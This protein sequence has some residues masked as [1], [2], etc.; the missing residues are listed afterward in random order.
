MAVPSSTKR[1]LAVIALVV[2]CRLFA[3][4]V[5]QTPDWRPARPWHGFNLTGLFDWQ[6]KPRSEFE[7]FPRSSGLFPEEHFRWMREWG[8]NFARLPMDYRN[9]SLTNDWFSI[10][11]KHVREIDRAVA[12][13]RKYGIHVQLCFHRAPGFTIL[14]WDPE[15]VR[16]AESDEAL[17]AFAFQWAYFARRYRGVP[18]ETLSFNLVNEPTGFTEAR[19]EQIVRTVVA[20]IRKEDPARFVMAD[21][22]RVASQPMPSL[23]GIPALGQA[24]RGY[25]PH[26]VSHFASWWMPNGMPPQWPVMPDAPAPGHLDGTAHPQHCPIVIENAPAGDWTL[27]FVTVRDGTRL[28]VRADGQTVLDYTFAV[29]PAATNLWLSN[30]P[31]GKTDRTNGHPR[32][33]LRFVLMA[34][35]R[36][37]E[38]AVAN[39]NGYAKFLSADVLRN[40]R[41][42]TLGA[43]TN[44][45]EIRNNYRQRFVGFGATRPFRST[46]DN[47]SF[48]GRHSTSGQDTLA[49]YS[50]APWEDADKTGEFVMC[51]EFGAYARV[52]HATALAWIEDNLRLFRSR[53][54]GWALW[55]L[56]GEFGVLDTGRTD[57]PL[58]DFN[59]H[60][61]DRK[62]LDLLRRYAAEPSGGE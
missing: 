11:E 26:A 62:L 57:V 12:F 34:P 36:E 28:R 42:A 41:R 9:W 15:P 32:F 47:A 17:A 39:A 44:G 22:N 51:G 35:A 21:G 46:E 13:G 54:W 19:Y 23:Y 29:D 56:D 48:E 25:A 10:R 20:A 37:L 18:N 61:L 45:R 4:A 7:F 30:R 16:L 14:S 5:V 59:G 53:G 31:D 58:E 55:E 8:F 33:P 27:G 38:I 6:D 3:S 50:Y 2:G 24:M 43:W 60:K 1:L 40:G 49:R 52:P